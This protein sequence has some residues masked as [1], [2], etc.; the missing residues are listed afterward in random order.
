MQRADPR[1]WIT[2]A[3][4][5]N[6]QERLWHLRRDCPALAHAR[7]VREATHAEVGRHGVCRRCDPAARDRPTEQEEHP[8]PCCDGNYANLPQHLA[9]CAGGGS[10]E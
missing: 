1:V 7:T 2:S 4:R 6:S 10:S 9:A 3:V 5:G 8:C